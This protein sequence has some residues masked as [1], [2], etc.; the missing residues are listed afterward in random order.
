MGFHAHHCMSNHHPSLLWTLTHFFADRSC[1]SFTFLPTP[2]LSK[3]SGKLLTWRHF[4]S[5]YPRLNCS[6]CLPPGQVTDRQTSDGP[7]A[8]VL[9]RPGSRVGGTISRRVAYH[10]E[11]SGKRPWGVWVWPWEAGEGVKRAKNCWSGPPA[12]LDHLKSIQEDWHHAISHQ[13]WHQ[14]NAVAV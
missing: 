8:V 11:A 2:L 12:G 9:T 6:L 5:C 14:D 10:R 7:H 13:T 4:D 3:T 1:L